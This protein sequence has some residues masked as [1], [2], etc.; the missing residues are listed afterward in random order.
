M[1]IRSL[2]SV[3]SSNYN[4]DATTQFHAGA[5]LSRDPATG[6]VRSADRRT[7]AGTAF[8]GFSAD[9]K[10]RVGN[11]MIQTDPVGSNVLDSTGKFVANNNGFFVS[12]KRALGDYQDESNTNVSDLTSGASGYQGPRRGIGVFTTPSSQFVTDQFVA[13][14]TT[15]GVADATVAV[16]FLTNDLLTF[17]ASDPAGAYDHSGKLVKINTAGDGL[18]VAKVDQYDAAAGLLYITKL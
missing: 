18:A 10:S 7:D 8:V 9:D 5:S 12:V 6:L 17:G 15:S 1:A 14:A 4:V 16:A 13:V 11:T 2:L 3:L